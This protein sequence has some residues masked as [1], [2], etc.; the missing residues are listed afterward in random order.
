M[1]YQN[2]RQ[3][4][5]RNN[6]PVLS[7]ETYDMSLT[8]DEEN[9]NQEVVFSPYLIAQTHG[10]RLPFYFDINSSASTQNLTLTYKNYNFNNYWSKCHCC[11]LSS[12]I[13]VSY[14]NISNPA[15]K[16]NKIIN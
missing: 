11:W 9:F 7:L 13:N 2:I 15:F 16:F 1:S 3:F 10:N 12:G 4:V 14:G 6:F 8:T 5:P